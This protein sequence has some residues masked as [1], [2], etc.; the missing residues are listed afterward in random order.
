[1][2]YYQFHIG[3]YRAATSHLSNEEDLAYRRLLDMYYDTEK[4]IILDVSW[5][6]KRIR[7]SPAVVRDVLNDMFEQTA[8]GFVHAR[9]DKE[10]SVY[11]GFSAAGKRGAAKRWAKAGHSPPITSPIATNNHEPIT[12]NQCDDAYA[13]LSG[14]AFPTCPQK[15]ILDL[16]KK[17]LPNLP[18]PRVWEG[19]RQ[20]NLKNRWIQAGKPSEFSPQGYKTVADGLKWW[21]SFFQHIAHETKLADGFE[22]QG[23]IWRPDLEWVVNASNFAKIIDGK[24]D[25]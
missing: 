12:N 6:A 2:Y 11:Q 17:H 16:W 23:R 8:D 4:P 1:M 10:I 20:V 24:Y 15:A 21:N 14:T 3:D 19:S 25:K 13:S 18:Q 7:I 5:V 22:T 9:C